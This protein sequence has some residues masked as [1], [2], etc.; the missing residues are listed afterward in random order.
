MLKLC[1][2]LFKI[3][4]AYFIRLARGY[5]PC[6]VR[7]YQCQTTHISL[8]ISNQRQ[9]KTDFLCCRHINWFTQSNKHRIHDKHLKNAYT[10]W[11]LFSEAK[12]LRTLV[13]FFFSNLLRM[14]CYNVQLCITKCWN[15][16]NSTKRFLWRMAAK[17]SEYDQQKFMDFHRFH[18]TSWTFKDLHCISEGFQWP[19]KWKIQVVS[20]TN[21]NPAFMAHFR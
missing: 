16:E 13:K 7:H 18:L 1:I 17:S 3:Q 9:S 15:Y 8:T 14:K 10:W 20:K 5:K 19:W 4:T 12:N 11:P 2:S 21:G 6:Y